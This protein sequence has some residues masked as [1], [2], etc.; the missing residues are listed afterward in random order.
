MTSI[1]GHIESIV[2]VQPENGFTVAR[3]REAKK[4]D[5]T[6]IVGVLPSIQPG[7]TVTCQG[8]WK[9]HPSHG[10]Q[11]EVSDCQVEIPCDLV[12]IQK[13]L[14]SGLVKG[15]G[16]VFAKKIVDRFG[17]QT[18]KVIDE[19]PHKLHE[20]AGLGEK[21]I[22]KIA[23]C[24]QQQRSI[25]EVMIFLR[26]H[27]VSPAYAQK[28]FKAYGDS[29]IEKVKQNP[30]QLAKDIFGI[31]FKTAD[32]LAQK[33][34]LPLHSSHRISAGI[35]FLL[36]ELTTEGHT[37]Y[38]AKDLVIGAKTM[39]EVDLE[40][41]E[42]ELADLVEK[43]ELIQEILNEEPTIWLKTF[44]A[45]EQSSSRD[46]KRLASA[47]QALRS[48]DVERACS[49]VQNQ[50]RIHFAPQ[51]EE[52]VKKALS[53]KVHII[54]GGPG[55]GKST[56][57][58]AIL[59]ISAKLTDKILLAAP[60]GRAAKRLSE[61]THRK[62]FTLHAML[63]WDPLTGGFK[64]S[65]DNPLSCDLIIIDEASMIDTPL[66]FSLLRAIPSHARV[67]FVGDIDQL[68]SVGPGTVLRD[69]ISSEVIGVTRLTEIFRQAK[70][71]KIITNAHLINHGEFPELLSSE[72]SD[73]Q[74]LEA[75]APEEIKQ[76]I[77]H[78][79]S[80]EIPQRYGF[81]PSEDIQVLS[82]MKRGVIGIEMLND[83]LQSL[84]NP[85]DRPFF[86][87]GRKFHLHDK[88]MQI[89]N[90]YNKKVYNG[91]IGKIQS[92]D[93]E[94]QELTVL[95]DDKEIPYEF[96][97]LDELVLAYAASVHKYQGSE[98]PCIVLPIHT[99]HFKLLHR[100]LL[101]TGVTRGKKLVYLVGSKKA[102][103]IAVKNDQI[104]K[105][106]TGLEK[107]LRTAPDAKKPNAEQLE[108]V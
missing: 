105:R 41:I 92:V 3:L 16:P 22:N 71:S 69:L 86:R 94:E 72:Q 84:L 49:W 106:H 42:K 20:I 6:V 10:R 25:R 17:L 81:H 45:Y 7:E 52:A 78:L 9:M 108:F 53:D 39:L 67:I 24:W 101:Y 35:Q 85:S 51:Q 34:G 100:N 5:S 59:A 87:A 12:G 91:D 29:S 8:D 70:G 18:L 98:C 65:K 77:L 83:A 27:G 75:D 37:C 63:E 2:Y 93:L 30:Y 11:F 32:A 79:V 33:L 4:K 19:T 56:I 99:T 58:K 14:E 61:I 43:K 90:N 26:S 88:V 66:F 38:P 68:P 97:E 104:H 64:R 36:W 47:P 89:R 15:V 44:F 74:F 31:G 82:P 107:A 95:F 76:K 28:I 60:T 1:T 54:T 48:I 96:S 55:T 103:A 46:M 50:L 13:Y 102:I 40:L 80:V 23:E 57:T 62:A 73:F 21:K